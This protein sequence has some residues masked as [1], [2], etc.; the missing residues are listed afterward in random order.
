[1]KKKF[2]Q[3][4]EVR[5]NNLVAKHMALTSRPVTHTDKYKAMKKGAVKHRNQWLDLI[6][7]KAA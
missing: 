2:K 5:Q 4:D 3:Q 1:M 6:V 7:L